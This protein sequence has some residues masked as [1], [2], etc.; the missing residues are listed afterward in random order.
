MQINDVEALRPF[1]IKELI[2]EGNPNIQKTIDMDESKYIRYT[3]YLFIP[4][5]MAC[6]CVL[7]YIG[8]I[9][10]LNEFLINKL[11]GFSNGVSRSV[12]I[13]TK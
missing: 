10:R 7:M 4:L 5:R 8:N 11:K 6:I 1:K 12:N 13:T 9:N 2:L 3:F